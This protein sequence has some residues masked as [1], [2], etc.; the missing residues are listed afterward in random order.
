VRLSSNY[1]QGLV[2][3]AT[4]A[5]PGSARTL[6]PPRRIF[7]AAPEPDVASPSRPHTA[8]EP[9]EASAAPIRSAPVGEPGTERSASSALAAP[10]AAL[11]GLRP[12]PPVPSAD[13]VGPGSHDFSSPRFTRPVPAVD[14]RWPDAVSAGSHLAD[15]GSPVKFPDDLITGEEEVPSVPGGPSWAVLDPVTDWPLA[16]SA[17]PA[18]RPL[19]VDRGTTWRPPAG[20]PAL[21]VARTGDDD[22]GSASGLNDVRSR[23]GRPSAL[24]PPKTLS[25]GP[26]LQFAAAPGPGRGQ[27]LATGA[28]SQ[29]TIGT[30]EVTVVPPPVPAVPQIPPPAPAP[31]APGRGAEE[32]ARMGGRRWFG[33]G[34]G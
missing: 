24:D 4:P 14:R 3:A 29:V 11:A 20:V 15:V 25:D 13:A 26:P 7:D 5:D 10:R 34:Q 30:I 18:G 12:F 6:R 2:G 23:A 1:L 19:M 32:A 21:P 8:Q 33:A 22:P 9:L 28:G 27:P 17:P 31:V 16:S